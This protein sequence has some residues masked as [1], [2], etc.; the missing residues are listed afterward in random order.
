MDTVD[1]LL[2]TI[3]DHQ[4][5]LNNFSIDQKV[6]KILI[7]LSRQ[8]RKGHFF[9]EKQG[10]LLINLLKEIK[11]EKTMKGNFNLDAVDNPTWS[12]SFRILEMVKK[13]YFENEKK[14]NFIVEFTYDKDIKRK[15]HEATKK[16]NGFSETIN[17]SKYLFPATEK[18]IAIVL[19]SIKTDKFQIDENLLNLYQEIKKIQEKGIDNINSLLYQK[20]KI[21]ECIKDEITEKET[22]LDLIL[23]DRRIRY[24]Y[25]FE[26]K[27]DET[28]LTFKIANRKNPQV[29]INNQS[30]QLEEILNSLDEIKRFPV[31]F[32]FNKSDIPE[33]YSKLQTIKNINLNQN[34][35][36]GI[37]FR[38]DNTSDINREFNNFISENQ[39]NKQLDKTTDI[40]GIVSTQLPKF[41]LKNE[42]Y[43]KS[44]ISFTNSFRQNKTSIYCNSVDLVI[45]YT[46]HPL[47]S[48]M[49]DE[50]M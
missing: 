17:A 2:H 3:V 13:V 8:L 27:K 34:F 14:N 25:T 9:T 36:I 44:V 22:D 6:K 5:F 49:K 28:S 38:A 26:H 39:F 42:W 23:L 45:Y 35:N 4:D 43:P 20:E 1:N 46:D 48:G 7:S 29:W 37:Y 32:V 18:N 50:I 19:D 33:S 10:K 16:T 24:Q 11:K 47:L 21:I 40:A 41:M 12:K 15:I 31:L 30:C